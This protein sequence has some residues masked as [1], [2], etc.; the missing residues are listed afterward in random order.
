MKDMGKLHYCLGV[1]V[2]HDEQQKY[3]WIH[4][5]QYILNMLKKYEA[6]TVS[7]PAD[8]NVRLQKMMV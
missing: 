7:M 1:T 3:V 2:E 8:L 5:K 4:Q 6:K